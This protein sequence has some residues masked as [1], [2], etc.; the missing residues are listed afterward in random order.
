MIIFLSSTKVFK[1]GDH[2]VDNWSFYR[3]FWEQIIIAARTPVQCEKKQNTTDI[4]P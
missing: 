1:A 3:P 2:Q 4:L